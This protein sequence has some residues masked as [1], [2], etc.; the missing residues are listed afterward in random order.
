MGLV[1]PGLV[2]TMLNIHKAR[3][4]SHYERFEH[5][6]TT[7]YRSVEATSVTPFSPRAMDRGLA[8]TVVA[9]ARHGISEM[10]PP[11]GAGRMVDLRSKL[12]WVVTALGNRARAH[13]NL[14]AVES[15][16]LATSV[17]SRVKDLLDDWTSIAKTLQDKGG[18]A[19][20]Y[21][22]E[23]GDA[24]RLLHPFLDP[25]LNTKS[26][27]FKKFRANRSMR[28]VEPDVNLWLETMDGQQVDAEEED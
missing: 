25:D 27:K 16:E 1:K 2:V 21:Q 5:Y 13:A 3:D 20:Q 15:Q 18:T 28:D 10:T 19:L 11:K 17:E 24:Q 4:R 23:V 8:G 6:H 9:L 14:N 26:P 7:F 22:S 12:D